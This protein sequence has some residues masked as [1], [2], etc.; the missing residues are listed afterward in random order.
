MQFTPF[1]WVQTFTSEYTKYTKYYL[2]SYGSTIDARLNR[3]QNR[4]RV[5]G[6]G[7]SLGILRAKQTAVEHLGQWWSKKDFKP[8]VWTVWQGL[9]TMEEISNIGKANRLNHNEPAQIVIIVLW[10]LTLSALRKPYQNN[11][12]Q[13]MKIRNGGLF[14]AKPI[15]WSSQKTCFPKK[16][17]SQRSAPCGTSHKCRTCC[18][19]G[20]DPLDRPTC[21][22]L[23]SSSSQDR[24]D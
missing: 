2:R 21:H 24:F 13:I 15:E 5:D 12:L 11:V 3:L 20:N 10:C 23:L 6:P 14:Q 16:S 7:S 17:I 19:R 1:I 9:H 18:P 4:L 22:T 8:C